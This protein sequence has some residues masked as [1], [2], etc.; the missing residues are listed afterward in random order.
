MPSYL[1]WHTAL[2]YLSGTVA[3]MRVVMLFFR[4]SERLAAWGAIELIVAVTPAN[5]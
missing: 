5:I 4:R 2:V 3:M 1:P